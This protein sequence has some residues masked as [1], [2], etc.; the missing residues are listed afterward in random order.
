MVA[1][2]VTCVSNVCS[3]IPKVQ[4]FPGFGYNWHSDFATFIDCFL[5]PQGSA[6]NRG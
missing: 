5:E 2:L 4:H 1:R 6:I 3:P